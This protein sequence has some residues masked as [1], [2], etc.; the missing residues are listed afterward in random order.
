MRSRPI[1][2]GQDILASQN[3]DRRDDAR[4]SGFLLPHQMLGSLALGTNPT[5][6]QVVPIVI[7]GTTITITFVTAIGSTANNVLIGASAT[8]SVNNLVNFL[9]RPDLTNASQVAASG[10]NQALLQY[11]GWAYP[12]AATTVVPFSLNKNVNGNADLLTSFNITGIT[13]TGGTW[14]AQTMQLYVQDGTYFINGVRYLFTGN[15]TPTVTAPV[16]HPRIDVL[17]IDTTGTLAWTTGTES[18]SPVAPTYPSNKLPICELYNVV[19]ETALYDNENQQSGQGYISNDVRPSVSSGVIFT[20][21]ASD[22]DPDATDTRNIGES[23]SNEWLGIYGKNIYASNSVQVNGVNVAVSK[24]GGTGADG[25]LSITSG[26]TT[27]NLGG[28]AVF[29]KNYTSISI[30]GTGQLAFSNP[31]TGGTIVILKSQ[32][33]V[34]ITSSATPAIDLRGIG[35]VGGTGG[36]SGGSGGSSPQAAGGQ[37]LAGG[38]TAGSSHNSNPAG[39]NGGAFGAWIDGLSITAAI[40]ATSSSNP[41][42]G[43]VTNVNSGLQKYHKMYVLP[44]GGGSGAEG[45]S[46]VTGGTGGAG[47]GALYLECAGALN[48]TGTI[49]ANGNVSVQG[50]GGTYAG[51]GGGGS[52]QILYNTLTANTGT[53]TVAGDTTNS[54]GEGGNGLSYV[55]LNTEFS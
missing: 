47:G 31:A 45:G 38:A 18:A 50:T 36:A 15:S 14:T 48:F 17:T 41:S 8:A 43:S 26:T 16:S 42:V 27:I 52:V 39:L 2:P 4:A 55:G 10:P 12:G 35:S 34:T 23:S 5:N 7:N 11:V 40:A 51:G 29:V 3:N 44:G 22:L 19:S 46:G 21:I 20:S 13:V 37:G 9:R 25:A 54:F 24:F 6:G 30:T 49:N 1:G 53:I 28:A 32:G 33:N